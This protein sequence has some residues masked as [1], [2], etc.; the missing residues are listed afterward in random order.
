MPPVKA[1]AVLAVASCLVGCNTI[2]VRYVDATGER[3]SGTI[4]GGVAS[5]NDG[6]FSV[7]DKGVTCSGAF[8][9]WAN[10]TITFPVRC[11]DGNTGTVTMTR[12]P[13]N[14]IAGEG[15]MQLASGDT[16]RFV[17]GQR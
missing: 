10:L 15:T 12:P 7:S 5:M 4:T 2:A 1:I 13:V 8:P 14:V 17:F 6:K 3:G 9:S 16:R 11:T